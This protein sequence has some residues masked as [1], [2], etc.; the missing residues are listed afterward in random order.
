M[1]AAY[2]WMLEQNVSPGMTD[3]YHHTLFGVIQSSACECMAIQFISVEKTRRC[4]EP[5]ES[6]RERKGWTRD[7]FRRLKQHQ[8]WEAQHRR[9]AVKPSALLA[10]IQTLESLAAPHKLRAQLYKRPKHSSSPFKIKSQ[11]WGHTPY[12]CTP[13]PNHITQKCENHLNV[14]QLVSG[15]KNSGTSSHLLICNERTQVILGQLNKG[16]EDH[17]AWL[18]P[19]EMSEQTTPHT[20]KSRLEGQVS[21]CQWYGFLFGVIKF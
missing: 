9:G 17:T 4:R 11:M 1:H 15:K 20:E 21:R 7:Y 8:Q 18:H 16:T 14:Y 2:V 3:V 12:T 13:R 19:W 10:S 5:V 6:A